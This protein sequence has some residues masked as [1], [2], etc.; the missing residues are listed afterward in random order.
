MANSEHFSKLNKVIGILFI[1]SILIFIT[2]GIVSNYYYKSYSKSVNNTHHQVD[3]VVLL[4]D[5]HSDLKDAQDCVRGYVI[6]GNESFLNGYYEKVKVIGPEFDK[7]KTLVGSNKNALSEIEKLQDI[8]KQKHEFADVLINKRKEGFGQAMKIVET[9]KGNQLLD[10]VDLII[11]GLEKYYNIN[12]YKESKFEK[13]RV[14]ISTTLITFFTIAGIILLMLMF[15]LLLIETKKRILYGQRAMR[16]SRVYK[17]LSNVNQV[18][19]RS[20]NTDTLLDE[21]CRIGVE[22][23]GF[24]LA[25]IGIEDE[26]TKLIKPIAQYGKAEEFTKNILISTKKL[27]IPISPAGIAY[28]ERKHSVCNNVKTS[29]YSEKFKENCLNNGINSSAAFP[30]K[31][32]NGIDA[33]LSINAVEKEFF[34]EAEINLFEELAGDITYAFKFHDTE[35]KKKEIDKK[36]HTLF[37]NMEEGV[38]LHKIEYNKDG[39]AKDYII[40]EVN[41]QYEKQTGIDRNSVIGKLATEIYK[42]ETPPYLKEYS[43]VAKTGMPHSFETYFEP[44]NKHFHI[45]TVSQEKGFFYTMFTDITERKQATDALKISEK[46]YRNLFDNMLNGF[47]YCEMIYDKYKPTDFIYLGVNKNF[48]LLTGLKDVVGKKASEAIPGIRD[49]DQNLIETY[50]R[51]SM[52]GKPEVFEYYVEAMKMW[53]LLSIYSYR[54]G[55]F[56]A[57]FDVITERKRVE[58]EIHKLNSELEQKVIDRTIALETAY[59]EMESFSYSVSHDLRTPLRAVNGYATIIYEDYYPKLDDEGKRLINVVRDNVL[60]M[61]HLILDLLSLSKVSRSELKLTEIDMK[62]LAQKVYDEIASKEAKDKFRLQVHAMPKA[63]GDNVLIQQLWTNLI[64]NAIKYTMPMEE[65]RIEIGYNDDYGSVKYYIKDTG[66]GFNPEYQHKLFGVFQRLHTDKEFEGTGIGLSIVQ[67]IVQRHGGKI[68]AESKVGE[69]A[70]FTF[71]LD[72]SQV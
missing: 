4:E 13:T 22:E 58:L 37:D 60:K 49:T 52:T 1:L 18:I 3:I 34:D 65:C 66:V 64:S 46:L 7:L 32:K 59:K 25:W 2:A 26:S 55:Y 31:L 44:L 51:V 6:T 42:T 24:L 19:I 67:K 16:I 15:Y 61:D 70:T 53:F 71:T 30:L 68:W 12:A 35:T 72:K 56:I 45:E 50:G 21:V 20:K 11:N 29:S 8:I 28:K 33:L 39:T 23:G 62:T 5:I 47:A 38:A 41:E 14:K 69:G 57:V 27:D 63:M 43:N 40:L 54:K 36:F 10:S 48:E 17:T 9:L